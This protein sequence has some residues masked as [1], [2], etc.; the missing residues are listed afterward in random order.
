MRRFIL[1]LILLAA[2]MAVSE[3]SFRE[4]STSECDLCFRE[5]SGAGQQ[6]TLGCGETQRHLNTPVKRA[7]LHTALVA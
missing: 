1:L 4:E 2:Y 5:C 3:M 7:S 6:I